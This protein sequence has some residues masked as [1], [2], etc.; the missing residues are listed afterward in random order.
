L[1]ATLFLV[2]IAQ[3][4]QT[5]STPFIEAQRAEAGGEFFGYGFHF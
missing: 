1:F 4:Q 2:R 5:P 3:A